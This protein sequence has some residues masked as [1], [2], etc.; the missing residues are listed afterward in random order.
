MDDEQLL[1]YSRQIMLPQCGIEGQERLRQASVLIVGMGGLGAPLAMYLAASGVG[2][3][4]LTDDDQVDLSNLQRQILFATTD[5]GQP[6]VDA[7][8]R[9]LEALNPEVRFETYNKRLN[10]DKLAEVVRG[11]D[12]VVDASDNFVTRFL[13][14]RVCQLQAK[15]LI[16]A[17]VIR[18][19]GQVSVFRLD[20]AES[21]CYRCLYEDTKELAESCSESGVIG[22][23]VGIMG[24]IQAT[25]T[26]KVL[27]DIGT[28]L[29]GR[30]MLLD[31]ERMEWH[32]VKLSKDPN[33]PVCS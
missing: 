25:E 19:E 21:P 15:P 24:S 28:T 9:H 7:A 31:A 18:M 17:A 26:I 13:L 22:S 29:V 3:L 27:L 10:G 23:V 33:C 6:K 1:R 12:A 11:V 32:T 30:V 16:S 8:R 20:Q 2:K 5:V 14:N 4:I